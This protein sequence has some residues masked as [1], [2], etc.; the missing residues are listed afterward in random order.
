MEPK[1]QKAT[2]DSEDQS[3]GLVFSNEK[4]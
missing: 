2:R 3:S 4:L 1:K